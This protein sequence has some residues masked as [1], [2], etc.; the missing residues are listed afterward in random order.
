MRLVLLLSLAGAALAQSPRGI[1]LVYAVSGKPAAGVSV[2]V[3]RDG[4]ATQ[5]TAD[6]AGRISAAVAPGQVF[7]TDPKTGTV[8]LSRG[9][10]AEPKEIA[11]GIPIRVSG[12]VKG[13]GA[14]PAKIE[15]DCAYGDRLTIS[16]YERAVQKLDL[17][18]GPNQDTVHGMAI[19]NLP[20]KS[21]RTHPDASWRF[22]TEW[23]AAMEAP[24]LL[25]FGGPE[26]RSAV[27]TV[28]IARSIQPGATVSAGTI[29]PDFGATL[30][31]SVKAPKSGLPL[32]L[33][34]GVDSLTP[35][36]AA[37][38][39]TAA[40][41]STLHRQDADLSQFLLQR[42]AI[43]L[44]FEGVTTLR[45]LPP[46]ES[47]KLAFHGPTVGIRAERTVKIPDQGVVR[48]ELS[49][50]EL[51]GKQQPRVPYTG[52]L[53]FAGGT[54]PVAGAKVVYSSYPDKYET[55]TGTDGRFQFPA[56]PGNRAAILFI[57]APNPG[58]EPPF[59]RYTI[60]K[61]VGPIA[62]AAANAEQAVEI[63]EPPG[64]PARL[65]LNEQ[66]GE[67]KYTFAGCSQG[68]TQDDLQFSKG[69]IFTVYEKVSDQYY[70]PIPVTFG[71]QTI[72]QAGNAQKEITFPSTGTFEV[73]MELT[74]FV[75]VALDL[76]IDKVGQVVTFPP[77]ANMK[78]VTI[79]VNTKNGKPAPANVEL[80]FPTYA[81]EI[82]PY[83][84]I[85]D[86]DGRVEVLCVTRSPL[87]KPQALWIQ[88]NDPEYGSF[89]GEL[90]LP[91]T[92]DEALLTLDLLNSQGKRLANKPNARAKANNKDKK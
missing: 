58:G 35:S 67:N 73:Y 5:Y 17:R 41:L 65:M 89:D 76:T 66:L 78:D 85:T 59:D 50:E 4:K 14:D 29:A 25:V 54:T 18:A 44:N 27:K 80:S 13:F 42:R 86:D 82:D 62:P 92:G 34:M 64:G 38:A 2:S 7:V 63:P 83:T 33:M 75:F 6:N 30:E 23:F 37:K 31:I 84:A 55:T 72:F 74:P 88:V 60:T 77:P 12:E 91:P 57:D 43:P 26:G 15:I 39:Q 8:L 70:G 1:R 87:V 79:E 32:G 22:T 28:K 48:I 20:G 11:I 90:T 19:P 56:V 45:G 16:E 61:S 52:V 51:L 71:K 81:P 47:L 68:Y 36:S 53:R 21:Q 9:F 24:E 40:M 49:A 3:S 46:I 69:P 10:S